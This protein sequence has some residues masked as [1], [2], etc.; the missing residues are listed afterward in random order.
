MCHC[1]TCFFLSS[2]SWCACWQR[3]SPRLEVETRMA[4]R[5]PPELHTGATSGVKVG[6]QV[7]VVPSS[8]KPLFHQQTNE[9]H[10]PAKTRVLH[11]TNTVASLYPAVATRTAKWNMSFCNLPPLMDA[12][13]F[14]FSFSLFLLPSPSPR[15][16]VRV[17]TCKKEML[18]FLDQLSL[19]NYRL[20]ITP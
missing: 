6:V 18:T 13:A 17:T 3:Q 16:A 14:F 15:E 2:N 5:T 4:L 19:Q 11:L 20:G 10:Q 7:F 1:Q 12:Q 9:L 8:L